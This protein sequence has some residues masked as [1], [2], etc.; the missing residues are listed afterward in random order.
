M[1]PPDDTAVRQSLDVLNFSTAGTRK[2]MRQIARA[3]SAARYHAAIVLNQLAAIPNVDHASLTYYSARRRKRSRRLH[4]EPFEREV[5]SDLDE[6]TDDRADSRR[7]IPLHVRILLGL[8]VG[9]T[10]G[11]AS[12]AL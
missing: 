2:W 6:H 3:A 7:R 10:L 11:S 9:A 12:R 4:M 1:T 5:V 8:V